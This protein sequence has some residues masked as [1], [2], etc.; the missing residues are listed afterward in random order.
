MAIEFHTHLAEGVAV[1][2]ALNAALGA[3]RTAGAAQ[4]DLSWAFYSLSGYPELS[5]PPGKSKIA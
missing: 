5:L 3:E 1:G 2:S 4:H